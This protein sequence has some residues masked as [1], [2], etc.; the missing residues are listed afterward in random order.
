M[1]GFVEEDSS[2]VCPDKESSDDLRIAT[3]VFMMI[4]PHTI[5]SLLEM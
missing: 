1:D 5:F 3:Y 2:T 4:L